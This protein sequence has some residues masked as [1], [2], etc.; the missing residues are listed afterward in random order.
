[1]Q[2]AAAGD[3]FGAELGGE[4]IVEALQHL[5]DDVLAAGEAGDDV[6][7]GEEV[8]LQGDAG[9]AVAGQGADGNAG[10]GGGG[11][12]FG[13]GERGFGRDAFEDLSRLPA[14]GDRDDEFR[15]DAAANAFDH[16]DGEQ[17]GLEVVG[18]DDEAVLVAEQGRRGYGT[19][20][21]R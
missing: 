19:G 17:A 1:M 14:F 13:D 11:F 2:A 15:G 4:L 9:G 8:A 10:V 16:V 21:W 12:E 18:A 5:A 3:D 6:G 7:A 20:G